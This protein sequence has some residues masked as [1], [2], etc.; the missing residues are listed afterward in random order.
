[1]FNKIS[2]RL[3]GY[4]R[5][6]DATTA[7][8]FGEEK[9]REVGLL[10]ASMQQHVANLD[11]WAAGQ[12]DVEEFIADATRERIKQISDLYGQL[13]A[14]NESWTQE[15]KQ[16]EQAGLL[17]ARKAEELEAARGDVDQKQKELEEAIEAVSAGGI[18]KETELNAKMENVSK[19]FSILETAT[20]EQ[21][22]TKAAVEKQLLEKDKK[23]KKLAKEVKDKDDAV[24]RQLSILEAAVTEL[25]EKKTE[26][27][28][29]LEVKSKKIEEL[30]KE[31]S[32]KIEELE[33]KVK[34]RADA[35][36]VQI[37]ILGT[38]IDEQAQKKAAVEKQLEEKTKRIEELE[39][40]A[41]DKAETINT[42]ISTLETATT[43]VTG[44]KADLEKQLAEKCKTIEDLQQEARSKAEVE[45]QSV[46]KDAK[47]AELKKA[48]EAQKGG[49]IAAVAASLAAHKVEMEK[50]LRAEFDAE[51][52]RWRNCREAGYAGSRDRE[53]S[54]LEKVTGE[55]HGLLA[56]GKMILANNEKMEE[57]LQSLSTAIADYGR[58]KERRDAQEQILQRE[59]QEQANKLRVEL[60]D[61]PLQSDFLDR[62]VQGINQKI[63]AVNQ[64]TLDLNQREREIYAE[65]GVKAAQ[66]P[67]L[68]HTVHNFRKTA[69]GWNGKVTDAVD[70]LTKQVESLGEVVATLGQKRAREDSEEEGPVKKRHNSGHRVSPKGS[71]V[72]EEDTGELAVQLEEE[73]IGERVETPMEAQVEE[74]VAERTSVAWQVNDR[75]LSTVEEEAG[76]RSLTA[77]RGGGNERHD[78][79][80]HA[81][82]DVSVARQVNDR[83]PSTAEE[84]AGWRS[85][86]TLG[87]VGTEVH[88]DDEHAQEDA[89]VAGEDQ[90]LQELR[91]GIDESFAAMCGSVS[92]PGGWDL[93]RRVAF[94]SGLFEKKEE[95]HKKARQSKKK[96]KKKAGETFEPTTVSWVE[97]FEKGVNGTPQ[98]HGGGSR[99]CFM[100]LNGRL[101]A[102][103]G[104]KTTNGYEEIE[105]DKSLCATHHDTTVG[106]GQECVYVEWAPGK[107]ANSDWKGTVKWV[108]KEHPNSART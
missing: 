27:A 16:L 25:A 103:F 15:T 21:K 51:K 76:R 95:L 38:A 101:K 26:V 28:K 41:K 23:I 106:N 39:K 18:Q 29:Q 80:E 86:N 42:Q 82:E 67:E 30:E 87:G 4:Y 7:R 66:I 79:D 53:L 89:S 85:L 10:V 11:R 77:L 98:T 92:L 61:I 58:S 68:N 13:V 65:L 40:E 22:S 59:R 69:Y 9:A 73:S 14:S 64:R 88:D 78:E 49:E 37:S 102:K 5:N 104:V 34:E 31:K 24:Q 20:A 60:G 70:G 2:S 97:L 50:K 46:E 36:S 52:E 107:D 32:K 84:E 33:K 47:I 74:E 19:Q 108:V 35:V 96:G 48:L 81:Q 94:F 99:I 1:L 55:I 83:E 54:K 71:L 6:M 93:K 75:E 45:E 8:E 100:A 44:K 17:C 105:H 12:D 57:W 63:L 72:N 43:E 62:R 56:P 91:N 3:V 90:E